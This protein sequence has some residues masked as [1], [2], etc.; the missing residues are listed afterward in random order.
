[1]KICKLG[2][3]LG[4]GDQYESVEYTV[5]DVDDADISGVESEVGWSDQ[6]HHGVQTKENER[7]DETETQQHA[8]IER[9]NYTPEEILIRRNILIVFCTF[10]GG[11]I[12]IL[13][14]IGVVFCWIIVNRR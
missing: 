2:G 3:Y 11:I 8:E 14:D 10:H 5:D 4:Q 7:T 1:M 6:W 12:D 13:F 9:R